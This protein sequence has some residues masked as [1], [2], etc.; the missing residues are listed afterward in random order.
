MFKKCFFGNMLY[1][2]EPSL[3][4]LSPMFLQQPRIPVIPPLGEAPLL[5]D[6]TKVLNRRPGHEKQKKQQPRRN[7]LILRYPK[8]YNKTK[9]Y[10]H[11]RDNIFA[12]DTETETK[13][14]K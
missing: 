5:H 8:Y 13:W 9:C 4:L 3:T 10:K 12:T 2:V 6:V 11:W 7:K 1:I 14:C